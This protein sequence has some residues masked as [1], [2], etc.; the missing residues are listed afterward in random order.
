MSIGL[1]NNSDVYGS[2]LV[3]PEQ[4]STLSTYTFKT[5]IDDN[6]IRLGGFADS[7]GYS[8]VVEG[9]K[10][11]PQNSHYIT[12]V[13]PRFE[14]WP[15]EPVADTVVNTYSTAFFGSSLIV[16]SENTDVGDAASTNLAIIG[17]NNKLNGDKMLVVGQGNELKTL[18]ASRNNVASLIV[19]TTNDI[20]SDD[21]PGGQIINSLVSGQNHRITETIARSI[22][23]GIGFEQHQSLTN[24]LAVGS[25]LVASGANNAMFGANG[26]TEHV[27]NA[28]VSG[29]GSDMKVTN[30]VSG[31]NYNTY[32]AA[33]FGW[34]NEMLSSVSNVVKSSLLTGRDNTVSEYPGGN[35]ESMIVGGYKN[36]VYGAAQRGLVVGANH[37]VIGSG[38]RSSSSDPN[39][40]VF[41][42]SI[43]GGNDNCV[44]V[45][46][47]L[48]VGQ[49]HGDV[50][51]GGGVTTYT[52]FKG[53][54]MIVAGNGHTSGSNSS[55]GCLILG[56]ENQLTSASSGS[57]IIGAFNSAAGGSNSMFVGANCQ[58]AINNS[59][60]A[61]YN[62]NANSTLAL[63]ST[64]Q[65][66]LIAGRGNNNRGTL[67]FILGASNNMWGSNTGNNFI[68]GNANTAG[69]ANGS[70]STLVNKTVIIGFNN[71]SERSQKILI[72]KN[73]IN[74]TSYSS[75]TNDDII[76]LGENN[77]YQN[78][79]YNKSSLN[80]GL[81]VGGSTTNGNRRDQLII[82]N[83]TGTNSEGHI[84]MPSVGKYNNYSSDSAAAT[85]GVPLYGLY[86]NNGDL[87]IRIS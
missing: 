39:T 70:S 65:I 66:C 42:A 59:L 10:I 78:T 45:V 22:V 77:D 12:R 20:A 6:L 26:R 82:T 27:A 87:K 32:G 73:L 1:L 85:G 21:G 86:H 83:R 14:V 64:S 18:S 23:G 55:K 17:F 29:F 28:L 36:K 37:D 80:C 34:N 35:I 52:P 60:I 25:N 43:L 4:N 41:N 50:T 47:S 57:A 75:G 31:T 38:D 48:I 11:L 74:D 51:S 54:N 13:T 72:G 49:G 67:G 19:G 2:L 40:T 16:G 62:N 44:D 63:G 3:Y 30:G 15:Y 33:V 71:R 68:I 79:N 69:I 81:I 58:G 8:G 53:T 24:C 46:N 56:T 9:I 84:I 5:T 76:I 61:G 7:T